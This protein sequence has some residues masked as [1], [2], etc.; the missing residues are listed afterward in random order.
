MTANNKQPGTWSKLIRYC[1]NHIPVVLAA[2]L[3]A[4]AGTV[5]T[6]LGPDQLSE[7]TD[8]ITQG[9]A[10]GIDMEAIASIGL[11]LVIIYGISAVLSLLQGLIMSSVTQ[12]VS[13]RLRGDLSHKMN[14]LPISYYNKSTTGDIL[15]RVT[16]DVDT[17]GQAL[18]QS[19]G[20]LV[21]ALSLFVGSIVMMLKTNWIMTVTA[22][23]ATIIGFGLMTVIMKK[24]QKY[25][26][27]QQEYLGKINGHVEEVYTGHTVVKAYNAEA[28]MR[29]AFEDLNRNLKNSVFK[30]QF[31]SGMMM[32]IMMFIGNLGF[33]AVCVV[34][35]VLATNG[36]ISFGVIVAF[37]MY[38][39]FFTQPLSQI[40]QAA[41]SLQSASA[42]S[43]RVFEFLEAEE[44]DDESQKTAQ[45]KAATGKVKFEHVQFAYE[46]TDNLVIR[47]FSTEVQPGQKIAIVGPTGAGKTTL[48]NLLIRFNELTGGEI[49]I[50]DTPISSLTRE[51]IHD[52]FCM[53]LQDTW[54]FEGTIRE[55]LI[56]NQ[57]GI[58]DQD[59]Q[60]ACKS[61]GLHH[62]IQTLSAGYDT[63]LND[64]VN[65]S[66]GQ[67]QQLTIAR[68]MLKNAPMLILDEAT[69]S[70]DTRTELLIQQAMD[71]L[72]EGRTSFVIAHRLSTIKNADVIL[73]LK[74][75]DI[76]ESG[77]H[78]ELLA[79]NGFYAELYN[80]QFEQAS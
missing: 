55:N 28:Q 25:F 45:L 58:T 19:V 39:R 3:S 57:T 27:S 47:D 48:V 68:A 43:K 41:Q 29:G 64:K 79:K 8:L 78:S 11:Y 35:A 37:M 54:L 65:L 71:R 67:K 53:V 7:M 30:A 75:G 5:L 51:N 16:N 69:S 32:P 1:R 63:V 38:V 17:I 52:Q 10:A 59:I 62:F 31:L 9:I 21:T 13:K 6:L 61:V 15:S 33:V 14:R 4:A 49:Y 24:S 34:G 74:D 2:V 73:V 72:M 50:D 18:N 77:S 80:S 66:A 26:Q 70:V 46:G 40:A 36:D 22:V 23:V 76:L 60:E 44:M 42:A 20:T 56:Y 12:K